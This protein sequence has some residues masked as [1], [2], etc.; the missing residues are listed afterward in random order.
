MSPVAT[1]EPETRQP[2]T[3]TPEQEQLVADHMSK[4]DKEYA[5]VDP[6][7]LAALKDPTVL[8]SD[9]I[10]EFLGYA[11]TTRVFQLFSNRR[12]LAKYDQ[13]PHPSAPPEPDVTFGRR[14]PREMRGMCRGRLIHWAYQSGRWRW[15]PF[16]QEMVRQT[17]IQFGGA[18]RK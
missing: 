3:R 14:G 8:N 12:D 16:T 9:E 11:A 10:K 18:P 13:V 17:G 1:Q 6:A 2:W 5:N 7:F 15:D 4:M